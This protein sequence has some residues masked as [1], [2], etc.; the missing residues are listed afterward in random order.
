MTSTRTGRMP[1]LIKKEKYISKVVSQ[2]HQQ[3]PGLFEN[4]NI[5][6]KKHQNDLIKASPGY[7]R[8]KP[9]FLTIDVRWKLLFYEWLC[10][11]AVERYVYIW[12][13]NDKSRMK[14][15]RARD[16]GLIRWSRSRKLGL[17]LQLNGLIIFEFSK[18]CSLPLIY[19][20]KVHSIWRKW[21]GLQVSFIF[22]FIN[23]LTGIDMLHYSSE[24]SI[25][26]EVEMA[27]IH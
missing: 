14:G 9:I 27:K 10:A 3:D 13:L 24:H 21:K 26:L 1:L 25:L 6:L 7:S 16:V 20:N 2:L 18:I 19:L 17:I 5:S 15:R 23:D 8:N 11:V 22:H 12:L 4:A